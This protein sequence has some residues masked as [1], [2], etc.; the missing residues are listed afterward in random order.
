MQRLLSRNISHLKSIFKKKQRFAEKIDRLKS[1][2]PQYLVE[3]PLIYSIISKGI[4]E[5]SE[6]ECKEY[7]P[8][9]LAAIERVLTEDLSKKEEERRNLEMDKQFNKIQSKLS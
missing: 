4:H 8:F 9:L 6:E 3:K 2:L 1:Y 7:F 5:L